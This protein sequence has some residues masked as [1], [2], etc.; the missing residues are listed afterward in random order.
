MKGKL[1]LLL[2]FYDDTE[3]RDET[4]NS[5][6]PVP[7]P[8][9]YREQEAFLQVFATREFGNIN[10]TEVFTKLLDLGSD[11]YS[12]SRSSGESINALLQIEFGRCGGIRQKLE[13]LLY[14]N[15]NIKDGESL[16]KNG[17]TL[18]MFAYEKDALEELGEPGRLL[19]DAQYHSILV[20]D[21][22]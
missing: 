15:P 4:L 16:I 10:N 3:I 5:L 13:V 9:D 1:Q 11:L 7:G 19:L 12:I 6:K 8:V 2:E 22:E 21:E 20:H 17:L 18:D 14:E